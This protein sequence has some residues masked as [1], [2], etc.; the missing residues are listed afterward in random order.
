MPPSPLRSI[1]A[2]AL[3]TS[4][5]STPNNNLDLS[6][7]ALLLVAYLLSPPLSDLSQGT[8]KVL[9]ILNLFQIPEGGPFSPPVRPLSKIKDCVHACLLDAYFIHRMG[10]EKQAHTLKQALTLFQRV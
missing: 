3:P 8:Q 5:S 1:T 4:L 9:G 6:G 2:S 7:F 10:G